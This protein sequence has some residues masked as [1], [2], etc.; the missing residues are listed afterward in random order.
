MLYDPALAE[1]LQS[2]ATSTVTASTPEILRATA[3][4]RDT[5]T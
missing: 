2:P 3:A 4:G 5:V 1:L